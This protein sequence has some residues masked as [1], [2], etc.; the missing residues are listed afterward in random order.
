M[1][2]VWMIVHPSRQL[3][4][5]TQ[6]KNLS[7]LQ[8]AEQTMDARNP[9]P[10]APLPVLQ[11]NRSEPAKEEENVSNANSLP[12]QVALRTT[13]LPKGWFPAALPGHTA[14][15]KVWVQVHTGLG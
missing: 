6:L 13:D 9:G 12:L 8:P 14:R 11:F 1:C 5:L 7:N 10:V 15:L 4:T 3:W 2:Y